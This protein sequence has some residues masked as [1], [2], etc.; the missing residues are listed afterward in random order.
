MQIVRPN[1]FSRP[2]RSVALLGAVLVTGLGLSACTTVEG[3]NALSDPA[4][5]EREVGIT[6]LQGL[7]IIDKPAAKAP[8]KT[9]RAP[10]VLP[11]DTQD[12]PPP[13]KNDESALLP[14][15]SDKVVLDPT[16]LTQTDIERLNKALVIDLRNSAGRPLTDAEVNRLKAR[17]ASD[18]IIKGTDRR[19]LYVPPD[20][21]FTTVNGKDLLCLAANG[22]LVP[23]DDPACPPEI[24][25]AL[26][27]QQKS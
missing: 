8:I 11:K 18:R 13:Q 4:T 21:Y 6:T 9:P 17:I 15:D 1:P 24:R 14:V 3:V 16:G 23:L 7:G 20:K 19:P 12:L 22:D 2:K 25:A 5:F 10:L 27:G 26:K